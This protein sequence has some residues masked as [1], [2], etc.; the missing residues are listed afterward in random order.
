M[1]IYWA[2]FNERLLQMSP[3]VMTFN[4][5]FAMFSERWSAKF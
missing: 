5:M 3:P 4:S 1:S 2:A